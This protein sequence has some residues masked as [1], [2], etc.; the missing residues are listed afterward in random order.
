M[1]PLSTLRA[2]EAAPGARVFAVVNAAPTIE[3]RPALTG[4]ISATA[5]GNYDL[6]VTAGD[7]DGDQLSVTWQAPSEIVLSGQDHDL[8]RSFNSG[9]LKPGGHYKVMV[10]VSD[11]QDN[12]EAEAEVVVNNPPSVRLQTVDA[13]V[14]HV[15][16]R[17]MFIAGRLLDGEDGEVVLAEAHAL[18][19][20]LKP[21]QP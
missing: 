9:T 18:F 16:G 6:S 17:K 1:R 20:K 8:I 7:A 5:P 4:P 19:V 21:G 15:D 14:D 13:G 2:R 3:I 12:A 11:G 10:K